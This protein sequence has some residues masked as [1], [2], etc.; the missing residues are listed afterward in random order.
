[1]SK[2]RDNSL[3][4][5]ALKDGFIASVLLVLLAIFVLWWGTMGV[6]YVAEEA[7]RAG[8]N[9]DNEASVFRSAGDALPR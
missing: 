6:G 4:L 2:M 8:E 1:M 7:P 5:S 3:A 9:E